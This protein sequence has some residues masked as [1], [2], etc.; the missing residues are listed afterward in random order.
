MKSIYKNIKTSLQT[1][2]LIFA[3][4]MP[5][6]SFAD[7]LLITDVVF[8]TAPTSV[9]VGAISDPITFQTQNNSGEA[10][11]V[12]DTNDIEFTSSSKTG[13]FLGATG[14]SVTTT[15]S[16]NTASRTFYYR[17]QTVGTH[18]IQITLRGRDTGK[19]FTAT[20]QVVVTGV[21]GSNA[22]LTDTNKTSNV[23]AHKNQQDIVTTNQGADFKIEGGRSRVVSIHSPISFKAFRQS[24]EDK[25]NKM[26]FQWS[27]GDGSSSRG[28][29]T[30]HVY[31]FE[32]EY[33]VILNVIKNKEKTTARFDVKVVDHQITLE[34]GEGFVEIFNNA[35]EELNLGKFVLITGEQKII[36]ADD[37]LVKSQRSIKIPA[38]IQKESQQVKLFFPTGIL[39]SSSEV[40][41]SPSGSIEM[42]EMLDPI[43]RTE[44][45]KR[46]VELKQV[47]Q[48]ELTKEARKEYIPPVDYKNLDIKESNIESTVDTQNSQVQDEEDTR[49]IE[50]IKNQKKSNWLERMGRFFGF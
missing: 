25:K 49:L 11:K 34:V 17:D 33:V 21:Q 44:K 39:A 24:K 37:T 15:M 13:E 10:E 18:T 22:S 32:G 23:S 30:E 16:K 1:L 47:L 4:Y 20:Q 35:N 3:L 38:D 26:L 8:V 6:Q 36:I 7:S 5:I 48:G 29:E 2:V 31:L 50:A 41:V 43:V 19:I 12:T 9:G 27:F 42:S 46:L 14:N 40:S 28:S 45:L